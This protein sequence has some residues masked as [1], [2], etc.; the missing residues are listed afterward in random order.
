MSTKL[1]ESSLN[2]IEISKSS[3]FL[4][5]RRYYRFNL[6][7]QKQ[8]TSPLV[9]PLLWPSRG[10]RSRNSPTPWHV[11]YHRL[12]RVVIYRA[13]QPSTY[14]RENHEFY[15][16]YRRRAGN[17]CDLY[18]CI[19]HLQPLSTV[20][21]S[22][23]TRRTRRKEKQGA[24]SATSRSKIS[25]CK[26]LLHYNLCT[27]FTFALRFSYNFYFFRNK[28]ENIK[29]LENYKCIKKS[30]KCLNIKKKSYLLLKKLFMGGSKQSVFSYH[31]KI[32][33]FNNK[34]LF[35]NIYITFMLNWRIVVLFF[36]YLHVFCKNSIAR[37]LYYHIFMHSIIRRLLSLAQRYK[38][39]F[40]KD[41]SLYAFQIRMTIM[42]DRMIRRIEIERQRLG[43]H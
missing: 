9:T 11:T 16:Y 4:K 38:A 8:S 7:I 14:T 10:S 12:Q 18:C 21:L 34:Y 20:E 5:I 19:R 26:Y 28:L 37:C 40:I 39:R 30:T 17:I 43:R 25:N 31:R 3:F 27:I 23:R 33:C 2:S 15:S 6:I 29:K 35:I 13:V 32:S 42:P 36:V 1:V 41:S 22:M 24:L